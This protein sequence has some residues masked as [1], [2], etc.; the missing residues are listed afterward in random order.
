MNNLEEFSLS[1]REIGN[2]GAVLTGTLAICSYKLSA[3]LGIVVEGAKQGEYTSEKHGTC[4]RDSNT[5][6]VNGRWFE[7]SEESEI[8]YFLH[9][10]ARRLYQKSKIEEFEKSQKRGETLSDA[11]EKKRQRWEDEQKC[12]IDAF[13]FATAIE[14]IENIGPDGT[15]RDALKTISFTRKTSPELEGTTSEIKKAVENA[16]WKMIGS[17]AS[18]EQLHKFH[19]FF[20]A[21]VVKKACGKS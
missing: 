20:K 12:V 17:I 7:D 11:D 18:E 3:P 5:V 21:Q 2:I 10:E 6:V 16:A 14:A 9:Y 4:T 8:K 15:L 13:A 19:D 1:N